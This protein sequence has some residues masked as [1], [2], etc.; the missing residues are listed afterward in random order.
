MIFHNME[1]NR[2]NKFHL[3]RIVYGPQL[4][5]TPTVLVGDPPPSKSTL[6]LSPIDAVSNSSEAPLYRMRY[7]RRRKTMSRNIKRHIK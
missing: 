5:D 1:I 6:I 3:C 7:S 4:A 2:L